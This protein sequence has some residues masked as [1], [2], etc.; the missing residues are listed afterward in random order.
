MSTWRFLV[1]AM[2]IARASAEG[3]KRNAVAAPVALAARLI[4]FSRFCFGA[5][6]DKHACDSATARNLCTRLHQSLLVLS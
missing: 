5:Q 1:G 4:K 6:K 3:L 2:L